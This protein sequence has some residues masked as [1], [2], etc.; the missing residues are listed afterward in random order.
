[1]LVHAT[2]QEN[3]LL[4]F[5]RTIDFPWGIGALLVQLGIKVISFILPIIQIQ[6]TVLYFF[7]PIFYVAIQ[8]II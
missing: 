2:I 4:G 5:E 8:N 6:A 1:M 3:N 7:I